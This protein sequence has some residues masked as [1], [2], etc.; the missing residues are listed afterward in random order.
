[1][2]EQRVAPSFDGALWEERSKNRCWLDLLFAAPHSTRMTAL[3]L[4]VQVAPRGA[5]RAP[6]FFG[7]SNPTVSSAESH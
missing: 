6:H 1:M 7:M 3:V 5:R 4:A 2:C